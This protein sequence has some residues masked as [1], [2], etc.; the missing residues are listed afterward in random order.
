MLE[1]LLDPCGKRCLTM[2][3]QHSLL[4]SNPDLSGEFLH[5]VEGAQP[6][7]LTNI[8]VSALRNSCP[9]VRDIAWERVSE[10]PTVLTTALPQVVDA[11]LNECD[12]G[13]LHQISN[14]FR[15]LQQ[16]SK[17]PIEF[18][19]IASNLATIKSA[20]DLGAQINALRKVLAEAPDDGSSTLACTLP[21][22]LLLGQTEYKPD[23]TKEL[24]AL[25]RHHRHLLSDFGAA[26]LN[27]SIIR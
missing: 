22:K 11:L 8:I 15:G 17:L 27:D 7:E 18:D 3:H 1:I 26:L 16:Q 20:P 19:T 4:N 14:T 5:R 21:L 13:V 23:I 24:L 12:A 6:E 25:A 10:I 2:Y 9:S